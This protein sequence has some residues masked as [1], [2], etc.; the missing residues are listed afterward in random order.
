MSG[1]I[2]AAVFTSNTLCLLIAGDIH[3]L[4][5]DDSHIISHTGG[6]H[7]QL[8]LHTFSVIFLKL[9]LCVCVYFTLC[10]CVFYSVCVCVFHC[11]CYS[12]VGSI[13]GAK[14]LAGRAIQVAGVGYDNTLC[15]DGT[16]FTIYIGDVRYCCR[17]VRECKLTTHP[18]QFCSDS[19]QAEEILVSEDGGTSFSSLNLPSAPVRIISQSFL[20]IFSVVFRRQFIL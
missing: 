2:S 16:T 7:T 3:C 4:P 18:L 12:A 13:P 1:E 9:L 5:Y 14:Q 8:P 20:L 10:V 19:S 11:V 6:T 17:L 15:N